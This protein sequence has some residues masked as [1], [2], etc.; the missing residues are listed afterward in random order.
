[1]RLETIKS[2]GLAKK[3]KSAWVTRQNVPKVLFQA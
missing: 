1:L 2:E 3:V